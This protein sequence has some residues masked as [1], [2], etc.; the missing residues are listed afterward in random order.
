[1][2]S[3]PLANIFDFFRNVEGHLTDDTILPQHSFSPIPRDAIHVLLE[4]IKLAMTEFPYQRSFGSVFYL[5]VSEGTPFEIFFPYDLD[6]RVLA[7][8]VEFPN[9]FSTQCKVC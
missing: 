6:Y 2:L 9:D 5:K 4:E 3:Y 8:C 1:V 7:I